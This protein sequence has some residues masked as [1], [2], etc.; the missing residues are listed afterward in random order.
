MNEEQLMRRLAEPFDERDVK[1]RVGRHGTSGNGPWVRVLAYIDNAAV[2]ARLDEVVGAAHWQNR[3]EQ[4]EGGVICGLSIRMPDGQWVTK[5]DGSAATQTEPFKGALSGAMK[6][7]AVMWGIG[8]Y[9]HGMGE[10][11]AEI[12]KAGDRGGRPIKG[13]DY[14]WNPPKLPP[15]YLPVRVASAEPSQRTASIGERPREVPRE[16]PREAREV[17]G[18]STTAAVVGEMGLGA[19]GEATPARVS[20]AIFD[21]PLTKNKVPWQEVP[22]PGTRA[23]LM[24]H[25]GKP[26]KAVP[27]RDLP[28]IREKLAG[29]PGYENEVKAIDAA[30]AEELRGETA[31][32]EQGELL[33]G[34]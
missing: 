23:N 27:L 18:M 25:G 15:K 8:R 4:L 3:F 12:V 33:N 32:G 5:W 30:L 22:L 7:A 34:E 16:V 29:Y 9:L 1:W 20:P 11:F 10:Q 28:A 24:G 21:H 13:V 2:M 19:A 31:R 17:R 26:L 6:R 14:R